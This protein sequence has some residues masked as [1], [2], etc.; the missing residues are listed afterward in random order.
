MLLQDIGRVPVIL[1]QPTSRI[2]SCNKPHTAYCL[3]TELSKVYGSVLEVQ[4]LSVEVNR[5]HGIHELYQ[6]S[7]SRDLHQIAVHDD[8]TVVV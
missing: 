5:M 3:H 2:C 4:E 7:A 6:F 8:Q 1:F